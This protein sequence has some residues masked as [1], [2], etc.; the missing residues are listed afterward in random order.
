MY[1]DHVAQKL[2]KLIPPVIKYDNVSASVVLTGDWLWT[3]IDSQKLEDDLGLLQNIANIS[4]KIIIDA[5]NIG[6]LDTTGA[7]FI[8]KLCKQLV[9]KKIIIKDIQ[10]TKLDNSLYQEVAKTLSELKIDEYQEKV[11]G[12]GVVTALGEH[13]VGSWER[14][15]DA[16]NFLGQ[17][18]VI[19]FKILFSRKNIYWSEVVRIVKSSGLDGMW[20]AALLSF[21]IGVTLAYEMAPQFVTYGANVYIVNFLG[22]TLLK[23]VTPLLTA[24]IVAG[25]TGASITAEI[26]TMKINEEIEALHT[27]GISPFGRLVIPKVLGVMIGLPII[28]AVADIV[29]MAGGAVASNSVLG[30]SF[31]LFIHRFKSYVSINNYTCG[32]IKSVVFAFLIAMVG[33][34]CGF[35][36]RSDANSIGEYTTKSVVWGIIMVVCADAIF[37]VI[38]QI[39]GM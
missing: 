28:T 21:L 38:F 3:T 29:S 22:I 27:M 25:R 6:K 1:K 30:I 35:S 17:V 36:V 39:L 7:Y 18:L 9:S 15:I 5:K 32:I 31:N 13:A 8:N 10:F 23:E 11:F 24:I 2:L 16:I 19:Y 14:L 20:V 12:M 34:Y 4:N 37:A 26:G 33:C